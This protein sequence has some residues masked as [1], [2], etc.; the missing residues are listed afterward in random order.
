MPSNHYDPVLTFSTGVSIFGILIVLLLAFNPP[1]VHEDFFWRK[2]LVGLV[3][4][5]ICMLG[6]FAA[7]FP[8]QCSHVFHF[9]RENMPFSSHRSNAASHHPDCER[10]SAHVI[11]VSTRTLCAAC[12]G[13]LLGAFV[14]FIGTVFYFFG[15]SHIS[16]VSF[17]IVLFGVVCVPLGFLQFKFRGFVRSILNAL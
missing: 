8:K 4:S 5:L 9:R 6:I 14:A 12:T 17:P 13:L 16:E 15:E 1:I 3:F 11:Q 7:L 2:P 10:F